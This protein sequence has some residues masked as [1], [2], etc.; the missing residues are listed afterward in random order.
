LEVFFGNNNPTSIFIAI[1]NFLSISWQ[2]FFYVIIS[3][4]GIIGVFYTHNGY[5]EVYAYSLTMVTMF[6]F[7]AII[8]HALTTAVTAKGVGVY[9]APILMFIFLTIGSLI[10]LGFSYVSFQYARSVKKVENF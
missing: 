9:I 3:I 5:S 1:G 4:V 10:C 2:Y 6:P 7:G 8:P